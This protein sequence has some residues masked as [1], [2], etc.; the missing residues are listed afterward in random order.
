MAENLAHLGLKTSIVEMLP[1]VRLQPCGAH[2]VC[3]PPASCVRSVTCQ[4]ALSE[5]HTMCTVNRRSCHP[6]TRRWLSRCTGTCAPR[7]AALLGWALCAG[8][9]DLPVYA[10]S[11]TGP[12]PSSSTRQGVELHLGDGVA[13]FE[14]GP[15]GKGLVVKT[16]GGKAHSADLVMLVRPAGE[17]CAPALCW[18]LLIGLHAAACT[19]ASLAPAACAPAPLLCH[20]DA[21]LLFSPAARSS[22]CGPRWGWPRMPAWSW[23]RVVA[24][25]CAPS[26]YL[27]GSCAS[28]AGATCKWVE[29]SYPRPCLLRP[30][31]QVDE[32]MQTSDPRIWA[33]GDAVEVKV[34]LGL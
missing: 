10:H 11:A 19:R 5:P 33:V 12:P 26:P 6:S 21:R 2:T 34:R 9:R 30:P 25:R 1:Q 23:G 17:A 13:G 32:R 15:G 31:L 22:A 8:A 14:A 29:G 3:L 20:H 16:Q 24:S 4:G 28:Q 27:R 18:P 7:L